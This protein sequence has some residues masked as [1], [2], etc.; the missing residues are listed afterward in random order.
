M[1]KACYLCNC[2]TENESEYIG[3]FGHVVICDECTKL[4]KGILGRVNEK[5]NH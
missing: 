2:K 3:N 5:N 4:F 1:K